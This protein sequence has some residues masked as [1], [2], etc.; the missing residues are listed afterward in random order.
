MTEFGRPAV[1]V[2]DD[3]AMIRRTMSRVLERAG[4]RVHTAASGE[5][6]IALARHQHFD[7]AIC[8]LNLPGISGARLCE[9]LWLAAP[10][11]A[12]RLIVASGDLTSEGVDRLVERTG[13]PSVSKPFTGAELI[14]AVGGVCPVHSS[15]PPA[16]RKAAS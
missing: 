14:Q 4:Y 10:G 6:A 3:E 2:V 12:G 15:S 11:L 16:G 9:E 5:E 7:V 1:L 13:R 8:D